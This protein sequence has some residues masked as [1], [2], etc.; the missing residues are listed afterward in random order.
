MAILAALGHQL[1]HEPAE[2]DWNLKRLRLMQQIA[3]QGHFHDV[4]HHPDAKATLEI[5]KRN[6][7][8]RQLAGYGF[9]GRLGRTY[10]M[11]LGQRKMTLLLDIKDLKYF[12]K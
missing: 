7:K 8:A 1:S 11:K 2:M 4:E 3:E 6:K 12:E 9:I 10:R 5:I